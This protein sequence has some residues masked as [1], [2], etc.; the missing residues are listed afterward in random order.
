MKLT[1]EHEGNTYSAED[2]DTVTLS[3]AL[4]LIERLLICAGFSI[5]RDSL[6]VKETENE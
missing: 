2:K 1:M 3:E 4:E 5:E 6:D